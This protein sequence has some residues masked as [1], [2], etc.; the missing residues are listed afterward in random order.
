MKRRVSG[1]AFGAAE[2]AE[3]VGGTLALQSF[4]ATCEAHTCK[5]LELLGLDNEIPL[6]AKT[7]RSGAPG[8]P[9]L[10]LF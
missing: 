10:R 3:K 7:A 8:M 6:L 1:R 9:S 4:S 2:V 5:T